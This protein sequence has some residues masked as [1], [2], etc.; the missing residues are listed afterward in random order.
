[1]ESNG[2]IPDENE[3]FGG[4][5]SRTSSPQL[6]E[7]VAKAATI[8]DACI[9]KHVEILRTLATSEGGLVSDDLRRQACSCH[10]RRLVDQR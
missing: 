10:L 6:Q 2:K 3:K 9:S 5:V 1:M 4:G 8:L 7:R